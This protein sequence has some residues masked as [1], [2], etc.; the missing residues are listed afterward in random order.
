MDRW[1]SL[2]KYLRYIRLRK[3]EHW[4]HSPFVF[5]LYMKVFLN[6]TAY[7]GYE[8]IEVLRAKMLSD[9]RSVSIKELGAG[10]VSGTKKSRLVKDIL[11]TASKPRKY[12]QLLF[13][14]A[15][16]LA[17]KTILELGTSLGISTASLAIARP[18]SQ[19][20][21]IEGNPEILGIAQENLHSLDLS[22][23]RLICGN[24]DNELPKLLK[25]TED[26]DL[27]FFDGNHR[28]EPTLS[29]FYQC[30]EKAGNNSV[31]VFDD[32]YWSKEMTAAWEIIKAHPKVTVSIDIYQMGFVFFRKEQIKQH[33]VL[34]Y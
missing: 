25:Q 19:I 14:I 17:P 8:Q 28:K 5:E 27:V 2:V 16:Y 1:H 3:N 11:S 34:K 31:F 33:F 12:S 30:L 23:I 32:I 4:L 10:S 20:I 24:F 13:R 29:Y 21:S 18:K 26:L 15:D 22:N 7:Y 9:T 6:K